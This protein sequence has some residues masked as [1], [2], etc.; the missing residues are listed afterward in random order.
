MQELGQVIFADYNF[1][2]SI[3]FRADAAMEKSNSKNHLYKEGKNNKIASN[4]SKNKKEVRQSSSKN[5][6]L[7]KS[8]GSKGHLPQ[9]ETRIKQ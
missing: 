2:V 3:T 8:A 6:K 9:E 5:I 7:L 4:S 1:I